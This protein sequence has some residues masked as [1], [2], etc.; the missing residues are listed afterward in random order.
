MNPKR[1]LS[2]AG[3]VLATIGTLGVTRRLGSISRASFFNPPYWINW[4]HLLLGAVV[5]TVRL[6]RS[7]QLQAATTL[8]AA[9]MGTTLGLAGLA[10]GPAAARR[11][12]VPELADPSDHLAHA[13]VGLLAMW[14][15][16]NRRR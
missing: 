8:V 16:G 13:I 7:R 1:F 10:F 11:Y 5:I 12:D 9:G 2:V 4:F 6:S 15:W 3:V 14:G